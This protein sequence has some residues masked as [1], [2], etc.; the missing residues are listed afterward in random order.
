MA[1][2]PVQRE[3]AARHVDDLV[4]GLPSKYSG[5]TAQAPVSLA[6]SRSDDNQP[7]VT[8]MSL[9]MKRTKGVRTWASPMFLAALGLR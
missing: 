5:P 2:L 6:A 8:S 4:G 7:G 1:E 9:S 3:V